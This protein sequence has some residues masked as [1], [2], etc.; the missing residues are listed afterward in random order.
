MSEGCLQ[1][2]RP[3][4]ASQSTVAPEAGQQSLRKSQEGCV[5]TGHTHTHTHRAHT[6]THRS[7]S[8]HLPLCKV[9]K[10]RGK[11]GMNTKALVSCLLYS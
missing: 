4:S 9:R 8:A 10:Q 1:V 3:S 11:D 6:H 5:R 2:K 7:S